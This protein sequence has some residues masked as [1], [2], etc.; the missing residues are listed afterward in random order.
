MIN[1]IQHSVEFE[2][3]TTEELFDI[4]MNS[5]KRSQ[6]INADVQI[7]RQE[8]EPFTV[9]DGMVTGK[10]LKIVPN[11]LVVQTWRGNVW[12]EGDLDSILMIVFT[13][14]G[15]GA[16]IDLVHANVPDQF[17]EQEKWEELY[18]KPMKAYLASNATDRA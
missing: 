8:G 18:W 4:L 2:N 12:E 17:V 15:S 1:V 10:N 13:A 6:I 7:G 3:A 11:E 14:T 9:F 16:R 5:R